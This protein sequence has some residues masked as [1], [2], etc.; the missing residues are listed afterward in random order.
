MNGFTKKSVGTLTL[1]EKLK[2]IRSNKRISLGEVSRFTKIQVKYLEYLEQGDYDKLPVDVYVRGFLR[3]YA[4]FIGIDE[5]VLLRLYDKERGIRKNLEKGKN[6]ELIKRKTINI[7]SFVFTP[8]KVLIAAIIV[9]VSGGLF[10]LWEEIGSFASAPRLVVIN[11]SNG[12][13]TDG[14]SVFVEGITEK[15]ASLFI[16]DQPILVND[17]GKFGEILTLQAG[18]NSINIKAVNKFNREAAQTITVR[19][20]EDNVHSEEIQAEFQEE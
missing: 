9:L 12:S 13:E 17:E 14:N 7:Y 18:V 4:D 6:P 20:K 2:R 16:N 8:K 19:S 11:P 15:D 10:F 3:S 5:Q 1:G